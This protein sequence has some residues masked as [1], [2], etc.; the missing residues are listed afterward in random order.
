MPDRRRGDEGR[1]DR[2]GGSKSF[3]SGSRVEEEAG[4]AMV[5]LETGVARE[6]VVATHHRGGRMGVERGSV[7]VQEKEGERRTRLQAR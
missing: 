1:G 3:L 4:V 2:F 6:V 5:A 7:L